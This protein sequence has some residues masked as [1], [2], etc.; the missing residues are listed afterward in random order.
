[1][2]WKTVSEL[3]LAG[4]QGAE[5]LMSDLAHPRNSRQLYSSIGP[6]QAFTRTDMQ[7]PSSQW[8]RVIGKISSSVVAE[9][10][11]E[12]VQVRRNGEMVL[13]QEIAWAS[14][15]SVGGVL[16]PEPQEPIDNYARLINQVFPHPSSDG[17]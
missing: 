2:G 1:M 8:A 3:D 5:W 12:S 15:L 6:L 17:V 11:S 16:L 9:V 14:H 4:N 7:L 10:A 13:K